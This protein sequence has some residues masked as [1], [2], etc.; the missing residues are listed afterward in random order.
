MR[1]LFIGLIW[2]FAVL[3]PAVARG[4][5]TGLSGAAELGATPVSLGQGDLQSDSALYVFAESQG[6]TLTTDMSVDIAKAG[7]YQRFFSFSLAASGGTINQGTAVD[8]FL[9]HF[10]PVSRGNWFNTQSV[11]G[12]VT[13]DQ[14]I[15]GVMVRGA[16]LN[17]S[18]SVLGLA[19]TSYD[20]RGSRGLEVIFQDAMTLSAD[21]RTLTV[22]AFRSTGGLDEVR[23]I[24][25]AVVPEPTTL[26]L[27]VI[28]LVILGVRKRNTVG[29]RNLF[30][31]WWGKDRS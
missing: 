30:T 8:S 10:D 3:E 21:M 6:V 18:D 1:R 17:A 28:G 19:G 2:L 24:T 22:D 16:S 5:V 14:P 13:F 26:L 11:A 31:N 20:S 4:A 12:S 29:K 15:L 27:G 7:S 9:L 25:A 23:I